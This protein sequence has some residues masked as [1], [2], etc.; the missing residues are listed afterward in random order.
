MPRRYLD[1]DILPH[2]GMKSVCELMTE[3]VRSVIWRKK[4]QGFDAAAGQVR[5]LLKRTR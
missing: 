5:G 3:D 2:I 1:K 4:E